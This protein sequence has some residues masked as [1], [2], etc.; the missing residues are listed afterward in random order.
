MFTG[1]LSSGDTLLS[2][3]DLANNR[4]F[5]QLGG[6]GSEE[7]GTSW[8]ELGQGNSQVDDNTNNYDCNNCDS[9]NYDS[10][11]YG[12]SLERLG[13]D[14]VPPDLPFEG[15]GLNLDGHFPIL[16]ANTQ[17]ICDAIYNT[18]QDPNGL[19][20]QHLDF[21]PPLQQIRTLTGDGADVSAWDSGPDPRPMI[22]GS[23]LM[24]LDWPL[25]PV[26][27]IPMQ[28]WNLQY[29]SSST[30]PTNGEQLAASLQ[31]GQNIYSCM[32]PYGWQTTSS[33]ITAHTPVMAW[34]ISTGSNSS[35]SP[36]SCW[37][38]D[39]FRC[40]YPNCKV[41]KPSQKELKL[42]SLCVPSSSLYLGTVCLTLFYHDRRHQ[43]SHKKPHVCDEP[44]CHFAFAAPAQL[45]R[46][47]KTHRRGNLDASE[48]YQCPTCSRT[49]T[50]D[51]N[52][53]RHIRD[54]HTRLNNSRRKRQQ[55]R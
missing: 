19:A 12:N 34:Q 11:K 51:D 31:L 39:Q 32:S 8:W 53:K 16:S 33:T 10:N 22:Q 43:K 37:N 50:R 41:T 24:Q 7:D 14:W 45:E 20:S 5:G 6:S 36:I 40:D 28:Y 26:L 1:P 21:C 29:T 35:T 54:E 25:L 23:S 17:N 46:H 2:S 52:L 13:F 48:K 4:F 9:K 55:A 3:V 49:Y 18:S 42:V 44:G 38:S 27:D 30:L 47:R 15:S